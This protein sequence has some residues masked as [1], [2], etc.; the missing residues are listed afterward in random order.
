MIHIIHAAC[1]SC[2]LRYHYVQ[3]EGKVKGLV[4]NQSDEIAH[5]IS[6]YLLMARYI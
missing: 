5:E 4:I 6:L 3:N 2:L 1:T